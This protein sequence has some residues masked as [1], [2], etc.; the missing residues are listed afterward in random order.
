MTY[1]LTVPNWMP[2]PLNEFLRMH[3]SRR[4]KALAEAADF[5][6]LY[7]KLAGV[8]PATTPRRVTFTF[9]TTGGRGAKAGDQDARYKVG[10]DGLVRAG[11]LVDDDDRWCQLQPRKK[12]RGPK[13]TVV[14]LEDVE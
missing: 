4:R 10:L 8:P 14:L 9:R 5:F 12:E 7:A 3:W 11:L 6:A 13:A 2:T 1:E